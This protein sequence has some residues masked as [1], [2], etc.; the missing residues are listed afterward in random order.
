MLCTRL[1][2]GGERT[3]YP[4]LSKGH[5][6]CRSGSESQLGGVFSKAKEKLRLRK[7][8]SR[9][10]PLTQD[11]GPHL[12]DGR[13][14]DALHETVALSLAAIAIQSYVKSVMCPSL[15]SYSPRVPQ[16][17]ST[18]LNLGHGWTSS[19]LCSL[20][21]RCPVSQATFSKV[22]VEFCTSGVGSIQ[23]RKVEATTL[24]I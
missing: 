9:E 15:A 23:C 18:L 10:L 22:L 4:S 7:G 13:G 24:I 8:Q 6:P 17:V 5:C 21:A 19:L 12:E 14:Q 2:C 1:I 11:E 16:K 20:R 3:H